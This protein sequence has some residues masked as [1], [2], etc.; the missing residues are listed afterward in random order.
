[1]HLEA[2][3]G[4]ALDAHLEAT[5][6]IVR[7]QQGRRR[8]AGR[9]RGGAGTQK[10]APREIPGVKH[11][12]FLSWIY[13]AAADFLARALNRDFRRAALFR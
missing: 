8:E 4:V 6:R 3:Q 11:G 9:S 7:S 1:M 2:A 12:A 13:L 5:I 10:V